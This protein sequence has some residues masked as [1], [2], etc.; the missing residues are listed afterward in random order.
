MGDVATIPLFERQNSKYL[1][2]GTPISKKNEALLA[3]WGRTKH[4]GTFVT[5]IELA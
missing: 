4:V 1:F 5:L 3:I 2:P